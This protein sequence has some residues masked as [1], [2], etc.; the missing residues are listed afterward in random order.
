MLI[1][2]SFID[3]D[4]KG[5]SKIIEIYEFTAGY[6]RRK[7]ELNSFPFPVPSRIDGKLFQQLED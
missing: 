4:G 1:C 7:K 3:S 6:Q 2:I 5:G